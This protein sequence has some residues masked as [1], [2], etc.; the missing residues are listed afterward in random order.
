[1]KEGRG[2]A[3]C[4]RSF[5]RQAS[6]SQVTFRLRPE[7][8]E[9]ASK[10]GWNPGGGC[11]KRPRGI[12]IVH[13]QLPAEPLHVL[14]NHILCMQMLLELYIKSQGIVTLSCQPYIPVPLHTGL[15]FLLTLRRTLETRL[16]FF[17]S[18]HQN[19]TRFA[20]EFGHF[21][22]AAPLASPVIFT[23]TVSQV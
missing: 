15:I 14:R 12:F 9:E 19:F 3:Y 7:D 11:V 17:S 22:Q 18:S 6:W 1:M 23:N 16:I 21:S 20:V 13:K 10:E 4:W 5:P 2:K 8:Q